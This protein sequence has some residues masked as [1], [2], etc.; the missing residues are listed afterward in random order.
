[1]MIRLVYYRHAV[2]DQSHRYGGLR[3]L[4]VL[5]DGSR[6]GLATPFGAILS[7]TL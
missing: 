6:L 3:Y 7:F 5:P 1:M 2:C 4:R